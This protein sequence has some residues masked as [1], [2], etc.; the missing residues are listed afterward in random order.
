MN[1]SMLAWAQSN[2]GSLNYETTSTKAYLHLTYIWVFRLEYKTIKK[3]V[4]GLAIYQI[5]PL[6]QWLK[7]T[8]Y[9]W[10]FHEL[11]IGLTLKKKKNTLH[12]NK[13]RDLELHRVKEISLLKYIIEPWSCTATLNE[14]E[15]NMYY[16]MAIL[17]FSWSIW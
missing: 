12:S 7:Q 13:F 10:Q 16:W 1:F 3:K 8:S 4:L 11:L 15:C 5:I 9:S 6:I 2:P 17:S 14:E